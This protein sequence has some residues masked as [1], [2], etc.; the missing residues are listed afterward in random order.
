M[1]TFTIVLNQ[2]LHKLEVRGVRLGPLGEF[3][4]IYSLELEL[5]EGKER[6]VSMESGE[7]D[8]RCE[9]AAESRGGID[10]VRKYE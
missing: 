2:L 7:F 10:I 4:C 9:F 6:T 1:N 5:V 8:F 3:S